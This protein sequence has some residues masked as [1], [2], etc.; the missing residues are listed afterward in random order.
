MKVAIIGRTGILLKTS[1]LLLSRG[2]EI[3][4]VI[5]SRLK[6]IDDEGP[7]KFEALANKANAPFICT[8][9]I[10]HPENLES[11]RALG[12][13]VAVSVNWPTI[14]KAPMLNA[15]PFGILNAHAGDL[16]RYRGN[17]CPNWAIIIGEDK[18]GLC[19]HQM[20]TDLDTGPI[21]VRD[22]L[23]L[24]EMTYIGDIYEWLER[25]VPENLVQAINGL[26]SG[27]VK[28]IEQSKAPQDG[29]RCYPRQ[30]EDGWI[31]WSREAANIARL[32]RASSRPFAGAFTYLDGE[33][34]VTVWRAKE[35]ISNEPFCAVS[36]QICQR[37]NGNAVIA[38]GEGMLELQEVTI[39]GL[40]PEESMKVITKSLRSRFFG[41]LQLTKE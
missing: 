25:Q 26:E 35:A 29:L 36:G 23:P 20:T 4:L 17:A 41:D 21:A 16:P 22:Y 13:A 39:S 15:F 9:N 19:I 24:T 1:E 30:P 12:C 7:E 10:N 31:D 11:V 33:T 38:C 6:S 28:F 3:G 2:H 32:V 40:L 18:I 34:K 14:I 5:T 37:R 8:T 27:T